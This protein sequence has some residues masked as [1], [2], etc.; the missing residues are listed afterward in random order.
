MKID[1]PRELV[2][3]LLHQ[4]GGT[5]DVFRDRHGNTAEW[6]RSPVGRLYALLVQ[7]AETLVH[8]R[9]K[10]SAAVNRASIKTRFRK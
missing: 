6:D 3:G 10:N 8:S 1:L 7:E 9:A 4:L 2:N 5:R